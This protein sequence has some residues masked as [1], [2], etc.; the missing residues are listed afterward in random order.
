MFQRSLWADYAKAIGIILV[1]LGHVL[2]G[3]VRAGILP[4]SPGMQLLDSIIYSFH[5]PLF[6]FVSGIF[7][8]G[9][10]AAHG[11]R[12]TLISRLDRLVFPYLLWSLLQGGV[13]VML[14]DQTNGRATWAEVLSLLWQPRAQFWFLYA[15]ALVVAL[16]LLLY[17]SEAARRS[18]WVPAFGAVLYLL[19]PLL[20][21]NLY[22]GFLAEHFVYFA[23]GVWT[24]GS[25]P[26]VAARA[27][28]LALPTLALAA[29]LQYHFHV[30]RG[31]H[32]TDRGFET[33][34]LAASAILALLALAM[35]AAR[36]HP[37]RPWRW[38]LA[39]GR[40]SM[41]I[42]LMHILAASGLRVV[43]QRFAGISDPLPH[44]ALAMA[45]GI[46]APMLVTR[47][48]DRQVAPRLPRWTAPLGWRRLAADRR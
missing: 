17:R 20:P 11:R 38:L 25:L 39:V 19:R 14:A 3:L 4:D 21:D 9:S 30:V 36:R 13:E 10:L 28:Q 45:V 44:I 37:R 40:A 32:Y 16:G 26:T 34:A 12:R 8:N 18:L 15:L 24:Q 1:V 5:V 48:W 2:R 47:L 23:A 7:F 6:F 46:L 33:L 43:L 29:L 22:F 27:G 41:P 35:L 42:F 31:L